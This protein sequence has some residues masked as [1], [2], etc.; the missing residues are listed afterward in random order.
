MFV[1][2]GEDAFGEYYVL[3]FCEGTYSE[4]WQGKPR[5]VVASDQVNLYMITRVC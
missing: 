4:V 5:V 2:V 3:K 1:I